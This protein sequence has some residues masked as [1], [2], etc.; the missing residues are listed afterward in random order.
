MKHKL[1]KIKEES[2]GLCADR[3]MKNVFYTGGL[4]YASF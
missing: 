1:Q 2:Q 3:K 4:R